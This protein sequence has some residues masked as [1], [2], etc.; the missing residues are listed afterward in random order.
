MLQCIPLFP[1]VV[2]VARSLRLTLDYG[3]TH[4]KNESQEETYRWSWDI[5]VMPGEHFDQVL[6]I[7]N[8]TSSIPFSAQLVLT[9]DRGGKWTLNHSGVTS[10]TNMTKHVILPGRNHRPNPGR[11]GYEGQVNAKRN[12]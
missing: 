3:G 5:E 10:L 12:A 8:N 4:I 7:E 9:T 6:Y 1:W 11:E 2:H